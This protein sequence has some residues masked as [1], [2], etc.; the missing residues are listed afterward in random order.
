MTD[1]R[2][3]IGGILLGMGICIAVR[4]VI[5]AII[6]QWRKNLKEKKHD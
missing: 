2:T 5:D 1:H 4:A 3:L 6:D